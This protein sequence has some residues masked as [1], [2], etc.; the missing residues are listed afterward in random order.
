MNKMLRFINVLTVIFLLSAWDKSY[1]QVTL[2]QE[3]FEDAD[4]TGYSLTSTNSPGGFLFGDFDGGLNNDYIRR[5]GAGVM[6][7][8]LTPT[9]FGGSNFVGIEDAD[10]YEGTVYLT[11]DAVNISSYSNLEVSIKVGAT[12][13]LA[14][15]YEDIDNLKIEYELDNSGSWVL[16]G[17]FIGTVGG[18]ALQHDTNLDGTGDVAINNVMNNYTYNLDAIAGS[19]V[20]GS[21]LKVRVS[22]YSGV[23]E[24]MV[25]DDI[26]LAGTASVNTI[27]TGT[28]TGSPF[29]PGASVNVPFT[30][31]GT[32]TAGNVYTAQLS[33]AS[34]SF[35]S[36]TNIGTLTSMANSGTVSA[37]IPGG[38]SA[39][40]GYR[41]HVLSSNPST[42]GTDNGSDLTI[43]SLSVITS[44]TSDVNNVCPGAAVEL[45]A[46][47]VTTGSGATLTWF[48]GTGGTGTDLGTD[49]PLTVDPAVTTTYYARLAGTCNTV[50]ESVTVTVDKTESAITSATSDVNNVCPGAA[51]E[52]TANGV[53]TGSGATLTWFTGTGGTG[54]DLGTDNP[55]TVNPAVT[56]TYYARLA[57]TC[58][59]VEESVTVTVDK[60]ESAITSAT[61]DVNNVC[62]GVAV[63]LTANGVTTGSGATLA[64]F[65]GT[66]GTG[67][68][69][70][71]DNPL[72]VN[73]AVT[74]TYYARLAGTCNTVEESV[75]VQVADVPDTGAEY[76]QSITICQ[77]SSAFNLT[78]SL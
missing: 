44:A 5:G 42:T 32:F 8:D 66:G 4:Y 9:G 26:Q 24:E 71:T 19:S 21:S 6:N 73:P 22:I 28:I 76:E 46:N 39:G 75:S 57:G 60:T 36:P 17:Q 69:L 52:L 38:S 55:L 25:F 29:C 49:N 12:S 18:S 50:E 62:P 1:S 68:D 14:T 23:Q 10:G 20:T 53:T 48:T 56:T 47:G 30:S 67:T 59:T 51:V 72:T 61:S 2:V 41:I 27:T 58:N 64:W 70:G 35:T 11:L 43:N 7:L 45:T 78:D 3:D 31:T 77:N 16:I 15:R 40:T 54:T 37:T 13:S 34:G 65:T 33:D 63:E 74:T